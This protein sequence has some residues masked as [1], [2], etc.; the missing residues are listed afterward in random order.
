ML[1]RTGIILALIILIAAAGCS[2]KND[3]PA[4][5]TSTQ[6]AGLKTARQAELAKTW[7]IRQVEIN[8]ESATSV[9]LKLENGS[10]VDGYFFL[11]KGFDVDFQISGQSVIYQSTAAG[12]GSANITSDRFSFTSTEDQG[13]AYT[14]K[15]TP[16]NVKDAKKVN[17]VIFL[18]LIYPKTGEIFTPMDTK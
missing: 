4:T 12:V 10:A 6:A 5:T 2:S 18:E 13:I 17:P 8:L 11:E 9:L 7:V 3:S 1:K 15:F 14:L 16:V